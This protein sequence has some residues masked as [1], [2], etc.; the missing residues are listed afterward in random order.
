MPKNYTIPQKE[1]AEFVTLVDQALKHTNEIRAIKVIQQEKANASLPARLYATFFGEQP[2]PTIS[3]PA[4]NIDKALNNIKTKMDEVNFD[5][6]ISLLISD[7]FVEAAD[8]FTKK[9]SDKYKNLTEL[10]DL[11]QAITLIQHKLEPGEKILLLNAFTTLELAQVSSALDSISTALE[12]RERLQQIVI[13]N[14]SAIEASLASSDIS[15]IIDNQDFLDALSNLAETYPNKY[16]QHQQVLE[17]AEFYQD[18]H[19]TLNDSA[20]AALDRAKLEQTA[21]EIIDMLQQGELKENIAITTREDIRDNVINLAEHTPK[22]GYA[23]YDALLAIQ[24][25]PH[26]DLFTQTE[27]NYLLRAINT[28]DYRQINTAS[29]SIQTKLEQRKGAKQGNNS[30]IISSLKTIERQSLIE[31]QYKEMIKNTVNTMYQPTTK[32]E[33]DWLLDKNL[34]D[35][36]QALN[37]RPNYLAFEF[38]QFD[39]N[40]APVRISALKSSDYAA[41]SSMLSAFQAASSDNKETIVEKQEASQSSDNRVPVGIKN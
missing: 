3:T 1:Q 40:K 23:L 25:L 10:K 35:R 29:E 33:K 20:T 2:E 17:H 11:T 4:S 36:L 8:Y 32:I 39:R 16:G 9:K 41:A 12:T 22:E 24:D 38:D 21:C 27:K 26:Q 37:N 30:A 14:I 6:I 13:N 5:N 19:D 18:A 31:K 28:I 15:E 7:K 34:Q